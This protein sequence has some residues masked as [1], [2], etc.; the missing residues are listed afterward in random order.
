MNNGMTWD[1]GGLVALY[2]ELGTNMSE[3]AGLY[4]ELCALAQ[5][6]ASGIE[7]GGTFEAGEADEV[8][9]GIACSRAAL[10]AM[11]DGLAIMR[12]RTV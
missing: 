11:Q 1:D 12:E 2:R 6:R 9:H 7:A 10:D 4:L 8:R 5:L 3:L